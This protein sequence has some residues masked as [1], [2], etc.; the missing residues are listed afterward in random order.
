M[1]VRNQKIAIKEVDM[2]D[3]VDVKKTR[4]AWMITVVKRTEEKKDVP[5][6]SNNRQIQQANEKLSRGAR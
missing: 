1:V 5:E 2:A 4:G 3:S 6:Q